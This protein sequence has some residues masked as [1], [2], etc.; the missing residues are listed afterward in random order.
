LVL[1]LAYPVAGNLFLW[2]GGVQKLLEG[3]QTAQVDFDRAWTV[4]PGRVHVDGVRVAIQDSH[5]QFS[6]EMAHADLSMR[7]GELAHRTFHATRIRGDR[8]VFRFHQRA[9]PKLE[10]PPSP[11]TSAPQASTDDASYNNLWTVH[12][13]NVD[14]GFHQ[15]AFEGVRYE[16]KGRAEGA[17]LLRPARSLWVGPCAIRFEGGKLENE[18]SDIVEKLRGTLAAR[19][20]TVDLRR[21]EGNDILRFLSASTN[22]SGDVPGLEVLATLSS[23]LKDSAIGDGA[24]S[25]RI[26]AVLDRGVFAPESRFEYHTSSV[27]AKIGEGRVR[28][29][30]DLAVFAGGSS[31]GAGAELGLRAPSAHLQA[32]GGREKPI[33]LRD[34][35]G[36]MRTTTADVTKAWHFAGGGA[37]ITVSLPD[38]RSLNDLPTGRPRSWSVEHGR[39]EVRG[40]LRISAGEDVDASIVARVEEARGRAGDVLW[41][42]D[43]VDVDG[44]MSKPV[45]QA[46]EARLHAQARA[47]RAGKEGASPFAEA[48]SAEVD[49]HLPRGLP[50]QH[51][52]VR[53]ALDGLTFRWGE[54]QLVADSAK[55]GARWFGDWLRLEAGANSLGLRSFGGPPRGW[56]FDTGPASLTTNLRSAPGGWQGPLH[57]AL[58]HMVGVINQTALS[59]DLVTSLNIADLAGRA[60]N[61]SGSVHIRNLALRAGKRE[62]RDWWADATLEG[63]RIDTTEN[64][65]IAGHLRAQFRDA[66]PAL[67]VLASQGHVPG[68]FVRDFPIRPASIDFTVD[69]RHHWTDFQIARATGRYTEATG[70]LQIEAGDARGA[71]LFRL[72]ALH[73]VSLGF[74]FL[75]RPSRMSLFPAKGWLE[76]RNAALEKIKSMKEVYQ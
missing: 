14:V 34:V 40:V 59:G 38:L 61:V 56:Q 17:F 5:I 43:A 12:I 65:D 67:D 44:V 62:T 30:G 39:G 7:L 27:S 66:L 55:V 37:A 15:L 32:V 50:P 75:D 1:V 13:E 47:L 29:D 46:V 49:G 48:E 41:S 24:G 71:L 68:W 35:E 45:R 64:F 28:L 25:L 72:S 73:F 26:D 6:I 16:G 9:L 18:S 76:E 60:A 57:L 36:H 33:D 10:S 58:R 69:R 42:T 21:A 19:I 74:D 31:D 3:D 11:E 70:R 20:D 54:F 53:T 63:G 51:A 23:S 2:F 8:L 52:E 4:W 22:L